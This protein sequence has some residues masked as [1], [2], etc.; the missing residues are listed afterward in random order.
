MSIE[1]IKKLRI[2]TGAGMM[3]VKK[4]LDAS[5]GDIDEAIKWLRT[6]GIA[7]AAKKSDRVAAE[8]SIFVLKNDDKAIMLE[9]NSETDFVASNELF[10]SGSTKIAKVILNSKVK[11]NDLDSAFSLSV[12]NETI[13]SLLTNMTATI[14]EKITLRRFVIVKGE[15]G[16]YKHA[17]SRIG[18]IVSGKGI[19]PEILKDV[20]MHVAAMNPEFLSKDEISSKKVQEETALAKEQLS[21]VLE[22]KPEKVQKNIIKGKV[23]KVLSENVLLEQSFVKDPSK[24]V[25]DLA[26]SGTFKSFIRYEVGEGIEKKEENFAEEVAKQMQK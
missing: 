22:G 3:D 7:K 9:I 15:T 14:G 23:D 19:N 4:A 5:N 16:I 24:K 26:G 18:V 1:K 13:E 10:I 6:N 8:G 17:N 25:K 20:S 2:M 12:D 11:S 21:S